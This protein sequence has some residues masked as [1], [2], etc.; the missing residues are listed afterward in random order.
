MQPFVI[1]VDPK[2]GSQF[3][4]TDT[5]F[6][7]F[8]ARDILRETINPSTVYV[9][10][11]NG[12]RLDITNL[13][14]S[15]RELTISFLNELRPGTT[16]HVHLAGGEGADHVIQDIANNIM[17]R[18]YHFAFTTKTRE[19][20]DAAELISPADLSVVTSNLTLKW[21]AEP[22]KTYKV[23][24]SQ[25]NSFDRILWNTLTPNG[26]VTPNIELT[27]GTYHW[28]VKENIDTAKW[29]PPYSFGYVDEIEIQQPDIIVPPGTSPLPPAEH[30][31]SFI[32][33]P[34]NAV[35]VSP[36]IENIK[37]RV[38]GEFTEEN[39]DP[40]W[41]SLTGK[42]IGMDPSY[43]AHGKVEIGLTF[44]PKDGFTI[45]TIGPKQE[46]E[47]EDVDDAIAQ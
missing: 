22:G 46:E 34:V 19:T 14:Y 30:K 4:P 11:S 5:V 21:R 6:K 8:F 18:S 32:D 13:D 17:P 26:E 3:I 43:K 16:Y 25:T 29:S 31:P 1:N 44:E 42:A 10:T 27:P 33:I 45:I 2:H 15:R 35:Q 39:F 41:I 7:V 20:V 23:E 47:E 36:D 12:E 24:L 37:I 9:T 38:E 28:R 40:S